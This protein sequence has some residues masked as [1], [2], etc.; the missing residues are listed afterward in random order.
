MAALFAVKN[1]IALKQLTLLN[2]DFEIIIVY[3]ELNYIA[4]VF[5]EIK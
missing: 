4:I 5:N 1:S 2:L 3:M